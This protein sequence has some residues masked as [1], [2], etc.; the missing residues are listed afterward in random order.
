MTEPCSGSACHILAATDFSPT[1]Q[2]CIEWAIEIAREHGGRLDLV[3]TL[4]LPNRA[5]DF[6]PVEPG[7]TDSLWQAAQTRMDETVA[8]VRDKGV[9]ASAEVRL[10]IPSEAILEAI[11]ERRPDLAVIGTRGHTGLK[12]LLLGSTAERV[13]QHSPCPVLTIHPGDVDQHRR[14]RTILI[15]TDFSPESAMVH[16]PALNLLQ[17]H[18]GAKIVLLNVYHLPYEYTVYGTIPTSLNFQ[19]DVQSKSEQQLDELAAPL[20]RE[21]LDIE[22]VATEGYPPEVIAEEAAARDVDLVAMGTHGRSG[23]AHLLLG[24]TTRRVVQIAP[25]PVLTMLREE[26]D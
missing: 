20:R 4:V 2:A 12:H 5:T 10:G 6:V 21:G 9:E 3:H 18:E 11:R 22:T 25:C 26:S 16:T 24:S 19:E 14:V 23:L 8:N 13:V 17:P 7:I 1:G 15:P